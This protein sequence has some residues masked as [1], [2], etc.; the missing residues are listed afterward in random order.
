MSKKSP[1]VIV[2]NH[3]ITFTK[4]IAVTMISPLNHHCFTHIWV[5]YHILL[6]IFCSLEKFDHQLGDDFPIETNGSSEGDQG[7][8]VMKFTQICMVYLGN[9][10]LDIIYIIYIMV[11]SMWI[12][13][14]IYG[15]FLTIHHYCF[16]HIKW[17][18]NMSRHCSNALWSSTNRGFEHYKSL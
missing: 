2:Q 8:V 13:S 5:N 18:K 11:C 14:S 1:W 17:K 4:T 12:I 7:E 10:F 6:I 3:W 9:S 16:A 15:V